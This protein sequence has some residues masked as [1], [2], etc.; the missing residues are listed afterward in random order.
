MPGGH[1]QR[2]I[3]GAIVLGSLLPYLEWGGGNAALLGQ[4]EYTLLFGGETSPETFLHPMVALPLA[5]QL[6]VL[7]PVFQHTPSRRMTTIGVMLL[8]LL[9]GLV[10]IG[11]VLTMNGRSLLSTVPFVTAVVWHGIAGRG[12]S[13]RL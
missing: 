11:G 1:I 5:G 3:N 12:V 2:L 10:I 8:S 6:L 4:M 9:I 13:A 7:I